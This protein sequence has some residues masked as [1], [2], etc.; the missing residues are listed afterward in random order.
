MTKR[1]EQEVLDYLWKHHADMHLLLEKLVR[2][3]SPST[4]PETQT[5]ILETLGNALSDIGYS[6]KLLSSGTTG[7]GHLLA[8]RSA[9]QPTRQLLLG[10]SD[11]VWPLGSLERMPFAIGN[12]H[13]RGPGVYDMKAGLV[14]LV[15]ALNVLA[16]LRVEPPA[17]PVVFVNSDE[18]IGSSGST[19]HIKHLAEVACRAFVLE[20]SM[21]RSGRLK[22]SRKGGGSFTVTVRGRAAHAGLGP[23]RGASAILELSHVI[24]KLFAL[25]DQRKGITVNV[26]VID[27]GIRPNVIAPEGRA[28]VDVRVVT[29]QDAEEIER[30]ILSLEPT[31]PGATIEVQGRIGR[32]P[33]EATARNRAL[34]QLAR[35]LGRSLGLDLQSS[36]AGGI[37]DGNTT[38][39]YTAT[40]DGLGA[41]GDGAHALHEFVFA[42]CLVERAALLALL[43]AAPVVDPGSGGRQ[44]PLWT[45][46]GPTN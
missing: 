38:S 23:E 35:R 30:E 22:T 3:E 2:C 37:S 20:P 36:M 46:P 6:P 31:T 34:W 7:G 41:V 18:E 4:A 9:Q 24:Q 14:Q 43:V 33:M 32:P 27:G 45:D 40:L 42:D 10:H 21:G 29:P 12:G 44:P 1:L 5:V 28:L 11:T 39:L 13:I 15:F 25:N 19:P 8:R 17:D 16:S 26:G